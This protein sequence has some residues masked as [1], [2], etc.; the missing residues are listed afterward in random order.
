[1]DGQ[2]AGLSARPRT[3]PV[4]RGGVAA[5]EADHR[6]VELMHFPTWFYIYFALLLLVTGVVCVIGDLRNK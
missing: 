3:L 5:A 4:T 1:M 6:G 2:C